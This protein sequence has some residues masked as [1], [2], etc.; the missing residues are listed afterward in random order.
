ML[1]ALKIYIQKYPYYY[2]LFISFF[3]TFLLYIFIPYLHPAIDFDYHFNRFYCLCESL[4]VGSFPNYMDYHTIDGY[5][6][7]VKL[8]YSDF[9]FVPL[10]FYRLSLGSLHHLWFCVLLSLSYVVL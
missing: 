7:L 3:V 2:C 10:L 6:Y 4:A 5:G 8:F 9:L 1:E